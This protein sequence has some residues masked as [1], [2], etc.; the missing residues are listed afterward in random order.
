MGQGLSGKYQRVDENLRIIIT[1][2]DR[3]TMLL[4]DFLDLSKIESGRMEWRDARLSVSDLIVRAVGAV[5]ALFDEKPGIC[6]S[7]DVPEGLPD[8]FVDPDRMLQVLIN[9]LSN[10]AKF[11]DKG[12]VRVVGVADDAGRGLSGSD[13]GV[14]VPEAT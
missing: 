7:L 11:T 14:G 8:L 13:G 12:L 3:L 10:A 2:S 6:L 4:N 5:R 1:E 9:L